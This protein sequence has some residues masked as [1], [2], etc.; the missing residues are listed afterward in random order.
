MLYVDEI[1]KTQLYQTTKSTIFLL[2]ACYVYLSLRS[3]TLL[4]H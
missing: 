2:F 3:L 4:F 1:G